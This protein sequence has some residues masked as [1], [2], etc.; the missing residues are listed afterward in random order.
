MRTFVRLNVYNFS[1]HR[2][3][4]PYGR[5]YL[6]PVA[7][8]TV[9]LLFML[10]SAY[11]CKFVKVI[12]E[13]DLSP[14]FF[15]IYKVEGGIQSGQGYLGN[16]NE[17]I[18]WTDT[19]LYDDGGVRAAKFF[20][21]AATL[22]GTLVW[23]MVLVGA[24]R[25]L[26]PIVRLLTSSGACI[27]AIFDIMLFCVFA[28]DVCNENDLKCRWGAAAYLSITS[29]LLWISTAALA[30]LFT[31]T[32]VATTS[33]GEGRDLVTVVTSHSTPTVPAGNGVTARAGYPNSRL[34]TPTVKESYPLNEDQQVRRGS[35]GSDTM[36]TPRSSPVDLDEEVGMDDIPPVGSPLIS[37]TEDEQGNLIK[38]TI[39]RTKDSHGR[40]IIDR[41]SEII[42]DNDRAETAS[43]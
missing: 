21:I 23:T 37:I 4:L 31:K 19:P 22:L 40:T 32:P 15:G 30:F 26:E 38:T 5:R 33:Q 35:K 27:C 11:S 12:H 18:S 3:K 25:A 42:E 17:C 14:F 13:D 29:L 41:T 39:T 28:S 16:T 20:A 9:A 34:R 7:T 10:V 1:C 24:C 8:S 6:I 2:S 43:V 36:E